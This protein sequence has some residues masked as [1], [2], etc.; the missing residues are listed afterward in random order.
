MNIGVQSF[1]L[2]HLHFHFRSALLILEFGSL[3]VL[4]LVNFFFIPDIL[5]QKLAF[6]PL[7]FFVFGFGAG[8]FR[9]PPLVLLYDRRP[10]AFKPPEGDLPA[11]LC[12]AG[13][14]ATTVLLSS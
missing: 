5:A 11:F 8:G 10:L 4:A 3:R 2:F 9:F 13:D 7:S 6:L 12:H 1:F 14:F